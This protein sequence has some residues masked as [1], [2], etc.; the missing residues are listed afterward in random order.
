MASESA[1]VRFEDV[2]VDFGGTPA[3]EHLSFEVLAGETCILFGAAGSGKTTLLKAAMGLV[4][5]DS[6]RVYLF[7]QDITRLKEQDLFDI[8]A[9]VG[10]LFQEGGLFDS[11][12]IAENVAYPLLN[13]RVLRDAALKASTNGSGKGAAPRT[14]D[15]RVKEAL[16]F[17]ELDQTLE[18]FPSELSGGMRRRAGIARA[19]VT[20]PALLLY[21]SPTAGLDPITANT[22]VA[23]ILKQREMYNTAAIIV[24]HRY[25]D[26]HLMANFRYNPSSGKIERAPEAA[27]K[28]GRVNT[29]F[30]VMNAG[31]LAFEGSEAELQAA[32][33]PYVRKFLR[34]GSA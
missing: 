2:S 5:P 14:V 16:H 13:Q 9:R 31:H 18:K 27:E 28:S 19:L 6:G 4:K 30:F 7:G 26:G 3:L 15:E 32:Q 21:D 25:L 1:I 8:R 23:L 29:R 24:T 22:I 10:I 34:H 11:L 17:V 12:T 33:D 20:T